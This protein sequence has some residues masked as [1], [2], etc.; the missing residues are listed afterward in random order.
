MDEAMRN[1]PGFVHL[2][3]HSAFSLREGALTIDALAKLAKGDEMPALAITDTNNLFGALEFSEKLAKAGVQPIIGLQLLVDFGEV[4]P[5]AVGRVA[6]A[7]QSRAS[8]VLL[9]QDE[10][11]YRNLMRLSSAA[12]LDAGD[13]Q[14]PH[15]RLERLGDVGGLLALSGGPDGPLDRALRA[16]ARD[17]AASRLARLATLFNGRLYIE[18]QRHDLESERAIEPALIAL[19]YEHRLP[20]VATNEPYFGPKSDHEAHDA[21]LCISEGAL[22]SQAERRRASPEHRFKSRA[23]MLALF[24]DLPEATQNS[25]EIAMRCAFRPTTRKPIM[26]RFTGAQGEAVDE[27]SEL[28]RQA[29]EGLETL[30]AA[31]GCAPGFTA[32]N[33][34]ERLAFELNVIVDMEFPG[35]FLIVA[36]FIKWAKRRDIPVGPGRGSGAGSLAAYALSITDVDPLRFGLL[37]ERFLNPERVSMPDFDIDFCQ[38]RRDEVIAYVRQRYGADR[39]AQIITFGSFLARGVMRNVGRVLEMPLGQVDKLAKLVPQNPASPVSLK[40]AVAGEAKLQEAS[41]GDPRVAK[42]LAIAERLEGLYSNA[43]T[44]AAGI[45]I[46][47]R[48]LVELS[49]LY[50]DP[51]SDMPATQFNMKWVEQAGLVKFDFLGLKTLTVLHKAMGLLARRDIIVELGKIPLDDAKTYDMLG[52]G[53]TVG[54]FQVESG[55]MRKALVEMHADRFEDI[56][57]LVALYRPGPM[58]NIPTYCARKLGEEKPDYLHPKIEPVLRE[59]FGVIIY[60]EQVMQIAQ[61]LS[62]YSLGEADLLRR[63]MGKKIKAEMD[64]QR[65]RFVTGAIERGVSQ[66]MAD[67]IFDLLAKF[68][69]YGFNKSH[70]A[71]YA[72]IAYW[73]AWFKANHPAQFIAASMSLEKSNTDK[74]AEFRAEAQRLGIKVAPPSVNGSQIDFDA[75]LQSAGAPGI[76]YALAAVKGVGDLQAKAIVEARGQRRFAS[77]N[78]FAARLDARAVNKKALE[79]LAAAGAF[80]EIEPDRAIAFASI[81]SMLARANRGALEKAS[82]QNALFG[83]EEAAPSKIRAPAWS[84]AE[85]LRREFDAVGFFVSGHPLEA[86]ANIVKRLGLLRWAEFSRRVRAGES[87]GRLAAT[88]LDRSERRTK[89]GNKLGILQFSDPSG[90]YEAILFQEGLSQYRD[91]LEKGADVIVTLSGAVEGEDVRAR[92]THVESLSAAAAKIHKGLRIYL[93]DE[94]PLAS[95]EE[96][97]RA[98][99][100][101]DVS[102]ILLLGPKAGEVEVKLP[103]RYAVSAAVA[104]ALKA[105]A[106]VVAVEHV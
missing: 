23:E 35:Y 22:I 66:S 43:S 94:A 6:E 70:A 17:I 34:R 81:E 104:G 71:A 4:G 78:D 96:R 56:I 91:A 67:E 54:V 102:L 49:P 74:L 18:L 86:Y 58:A 33:Y 47:D 93:R 77:L 89:S 29:G 24:A 62:G 68:A 100:E 61:L 95:I 31:Y 73:T 90:Q 55:G 97:L 103:G 64:A 80:D 48:P 105:V 21:L 28:R 60:Q 5:S 30:L 59:T 27:V 20:L 76:A 79:S 84:E 83:E 7:R 15:V 36:D 9:A 37:F 2:H 72:L 44:H 98:K 53:E 99:G 26:P 10:R 12:W 16:G 8:L 41:S 11:G 51:K 3:V 45:V 92:V 1:S 25:V 19:A 69:D 101:G 38:D 40:Q 82:G 52:R 50:R 85:K 75:S 57:A 13:A 106:G 32:E 39:V 87:G 88:V 42:M 65:A 46:A 63:A 14:E